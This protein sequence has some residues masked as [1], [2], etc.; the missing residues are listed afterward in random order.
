M[1]DSQR[2]WSLLVIAANLARSL[3]EAVPLVCRFRFDQ[4]HRDPVDEHR[5]IEPDR[6]GIW[7]GPEAKLIGHVERVRSWIVSPQKADISLAALFLYEHGL[8]ATK[9]LP[10]DEIALNRRKH[11]SQAMCEVFGARSVD[12]PGIEPLKLA[13]E[14][15]RQND[16]GFITPHC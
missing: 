4:Q 3:G 14:N 16:S 5:H 13:Y 6:L 12:V 7:P 1:Q 11:P 2:L 9:V 15:L 8:G 10:Y